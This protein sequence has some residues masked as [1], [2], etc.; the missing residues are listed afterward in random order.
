M[1]DTNEPDTNEPDASA[2][3]MLPEDMKE[4]PV[5]LQFLITVADALESRIDYNFNSVIQISMLVEFLYTKLGEKGIEIPLDEEFEAFQKTRFTEIQSEF[6]KI[7]EES[8]PQQAADEFLK[9][10]VNLEDD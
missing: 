9:Q 4:K 3:D 5:P 1:T 8:N 10:N 7:K 6:D 2:A